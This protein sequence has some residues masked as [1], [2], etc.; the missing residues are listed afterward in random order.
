MPL[1]HCRRDI[2]EV[3]LFVVE[4]TVVMTT[5]NTKCVMFTSSLSL[6]LIYGQIQNIYSVNFPLHQRQRTLIFV[7]LAWKIL[8][9]HFESVSM[10]TVLFPMPMEKKRVE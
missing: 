5:H 3:L 4:N 9:C 10:V 2:F 8:Y 7:F 6:T 1:F